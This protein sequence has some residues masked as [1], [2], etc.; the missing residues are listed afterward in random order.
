MINHSKPHYDTERLNSVPFTSVAEWL[1]ETK[2]RGC[3]N[4]TYCPWHDDSHPSLVLYENGNENRC[5]CFSCGCG[6]DIISYVMKHEGVDFANACEMLSQKFGIDTK[7]VNSYRPVSIAPR[8]SAKA[9]TP[10]TYIPADYVEK[11]MTREN[12]FCQCLSKLVD[13][14]I[15]DYLTEEY[16]LGRYDCGWIDNG[17]LFW[18]IDING[19]VRNGKV[20]VY[21]TDIDSPSFMHYDK[22]PGKMMWIGKQLVKSGVVH[23]PNPNF[24]IN[25]LFGE[26]LLRRNPNSLVILTE[27][28]KNALLGAAFM[29][30]YLWLAAGNKSALKRSNLEVLRGRDVQVYADLDAIDEWTCLLDSMRDIANFHVSDFCRTMAPEGNDKYDIAD[31]LVDTRLGRYTA[32]R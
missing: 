15:V 10:V 9:V 16:L 8:H 12:S 17:T 11:Q 7:A 22:S 20:Q 6:G 4:V 3:H 2:R 26:H 18:T 30:Q 19:N 13:S 28:P 24:D 5:H 31:F 23:E 32:G 1:D 25:A 21:C 27:S 14:H 29:P